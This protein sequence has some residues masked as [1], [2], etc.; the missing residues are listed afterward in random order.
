MCDADN[1]GAEVNDLRQFEMLCIVHNVLR[2]LCVVGVVIC[3]LWER[4]V[5][6]AVIVLGD[7]AENTAITKTI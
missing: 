7:I 3:T 2:H 5:R 4:E 6:K 1:M